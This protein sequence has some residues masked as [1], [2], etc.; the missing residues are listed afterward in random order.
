MTAG[1]DLLTCIEPIL[2]LIDKAAD[3]ANAE[4]RPD[5]AVFRN[6]AEAGL[7]RLLAPTDYGG[8]GAHPADFLALMEAVA[9]VDG[10]TAWT[11]MTI[12]EEVGIA[13][14]YLPPASMAGLLTDRPDVIIAGAGAAAG[15]AVRRPGGWSITGRW[16][17]VSGSTVADHLILNSWVDGGTDARARRQMCFALVPVAEAEILDTWH[18]AGLAGTASNDVV[19]TEAF[20]P[21][22]RAGVV[23]LGEGPKPDTP[24]YNLPNGLRF[25]YP[26]V[27]V[28]LGIASAALAEFRTLAETKTP[29]LSS[30]RLA[31]RPYAQR[32][33]AEAEMHIG[34]GRAWVLDQLG[35]LWPIAEAG[36]PIPPAVHAR[37]RLSCAGAVDGAGRA[38]AALASAA[39]TTASE[40]LG[41]WPR[42]LAD[43]RAVGQHFMVAPYQMDTAGRVLLGQ[44]PDDPMF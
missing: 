35:E 40:H 5:P 22:E 13:S 33:V 41:P 16:P 42:L 18:M 15:Q 21:D 9:R 6:L 31:R 8:H 1:S 2:P 20:V 28:A 12:N 3:Q 23:A 24:F 11:M 43:V 4:R 36:E 10:S 30:R 39:G 34:A 26:K 38:V 14:A 32:A 37:V 7:L 29:G 17:F 44:D 25:P 27:G 19:L